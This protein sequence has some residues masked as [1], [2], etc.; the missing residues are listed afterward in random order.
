M[1]GAEVIS[2]WEK[3]APMDAGRKYVVRAIAVLV[4]LAAAATLRWELASGCFRGLDETGSENAEIRDASVVPSSGQIDPDSLHTAIDLAAD[5]LVQA[6]G[7]DGRFVYLAYRDPNMGPSDDYNM[8]RHAGAIYA[9]GMHYQRRPAD[10]VRDAMLRATRYLKETAVAPVP[11]REEL[12]AIWRCPEE[13]EMQAPIHAT[14]GGTGLG[15]IA[16]ASTEQAVPGTTSMEDLRR[17]GRFLAI[18]Q[19]EDGRF[20]H[21]YVPSLGGHSDYG[22][23]LYYP[24]EAA[25][26]LLMLYRLDPNPLWLDTAAK[27]LA[28]LARTR[29]NDAEVPPDHWALLATAELLPHIDRCT[30]ITSRRQLLRHAAQVCRS[31][32]AYHARTLAP[33]C[34][35][36]CLTGDNR[37][38]P[39][40]TRL[41]GML[42]VYPMLLDEPEAFRGQVAAAVADG[43]AFLVRSQF[44]A[45][46][47]KGGIPAVSSP[48][49]DGHPDCSEWYNAGTGE[50]RIDFVQHAASA[51]IQFEDLLAS[52]TNGSNRP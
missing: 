31:I 26:G 23:C 21:S 19:E 42:A 22:Q 51:M 20:Y 37:T 13:G 33:G 18:L 17:V 12:L 44:T 46:P 41:E 9:L 39:T 14:L 16:L 32:L 49:P 4:G 5:Y 48:V 29:E 2:R 30:S 40:A 6:C 7:P 45:D 35:P 28:Y 25:L 47:L 50:V 1:S 43:I 24:G 11:G 52:Q 36:Q 15:L 27:A 8:V 38:C 10:R 3:A 34:D